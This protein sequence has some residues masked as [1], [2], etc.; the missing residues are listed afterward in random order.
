MLPRIEKIQKVLKGNAY[1]TSREELY[2]YLQ[3]LFSYIQTQD[4]MIE[5]QAEYYQ[6]YAKLRVHED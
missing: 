4:R 6:E 5:N 2:S 3:Y 1:T